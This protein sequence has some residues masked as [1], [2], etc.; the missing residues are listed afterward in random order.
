MWVLGI[1]MMLV[2][3]IIHTLGSTMWLD[4]VASRYSDLKVKGTTIHL[5]VAILTTAMVLLFLHTIEV[6]L[7]GR[8]AR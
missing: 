2:T 8:G 3:I 5:F 6:I 1:L 4:I 7:W